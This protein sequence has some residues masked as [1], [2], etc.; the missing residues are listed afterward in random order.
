MIDRDSAGRVDIRL[1]AHGEGFFHVGFGNVG[2]SLRRIHPCIDARCRELDSWDDRQNR[3]MQVSRR[4]FQDF[5]VE[6]A[7]SLMALDRTQ[8]ILFYPHEICRRGD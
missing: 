1:Q 4:R 3:P 5:M 2:H 6:D 7:L 8:G